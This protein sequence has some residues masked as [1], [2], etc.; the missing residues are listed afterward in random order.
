MHSGLHAVHDLASVDATTW[1][2]TGG[3]PTLA[4]T[5]VPSA[6]W[7]L[8]TTDLQGTSEF[9]DEAP[10]DA[11]IAL[12]FMPA[13]G[14]VMLARRPIPAVAGRR[15]RVVH[16]PEGTERVHLDVSPWLSELTVATVNFRS[17]P[18]AAAASMMSADV[19]ASGIGG[20]TDR[21]G[22]LTDV[23][24][25]FKRGGV[26]GSIEQ[27]AVAYE[28]LQHRRAGDG[29]DYPSWRIRN[30]TLFDDDVDRLRG[31]LVDL[32]GGGPSFT[33]VM[34]TYEPEERWLRAAIDSV[35]NQIHTRWQLVIVDDASPGPTARR[36]LADYAHDH[37]ILVH[38]RSENGHIAAA[39]N[40]GIERATGEFVAFMD[41]DDELAPA[42][43][44]LLALASPQADVLY[45]DEDKIDENGKHFDPHCKP[46]WNPELLFGQNY[47]SHLTAIRRIVLQ[48]AGGLRTGMDGSQDHD[49]LLRV[50]ALTAPD[51]IVHV[52]HI[53]YHWRAIS[54]STAL[55]TGAKDYVEAAS[56][57][58]LRERLGDGWTVGTAAA[59]TAYRCTPP[60]PDDIP[61]VSI[62]IPTRDRADLLE[63]CVASLARTTW[64]AFEIVIID[65]DSSDPETLEWL[66]AFDNGHDRRVVRH[67]GAFNYSE[68]NNHGAAEARGELLCL[69]NNDTEVIDPDWLTEMVRWVGQPGIG[70]VGAKLLYGDDRIQHAG[71][72]LGLGGLAGHGHHLLDADAY[73][74]FSRLTIAHEVGAVTAACMLTLRSTWDLLGGLDPELA[75]AFNDVDYCLRVRHHAGQRIIWTPHALLHHHE[76]LSRGA[77]D[78]PVK[79]A[80]FNAEVETAL[81]RWSDHLADDPAYSPNLTLDAESF[82]LAR[83]P[84]VKA[85]WADPAERAD[86]GEG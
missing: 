58:A 39:T 67:P 37:R 75:V 57:A 25:A 34:P 35:R 56:I 19:A 46:A 53:A 43:L 9:V 16:V 50:T 81:E 79:V 36:V 71:V 8:V 82:T 78:D 60:I 44:A 52:P 65:N 59:P 7:Y 27:V 23:R 69:L 28:H 68:V 31:R 85:P 42:A 77:E 1:R 73:G 72:V 55:D 64:P 47:M 24:A 17:L 74:Y 63:Q 51:R 12:R 18:Q 62:L 84:R 22:L 40:D 83:Q 70:A 30:A 6:G 3:R 33:I 10:D 45:T 4:L 80:R 61:L 14:S 38:H 11:P 66:E 41:H 2:I 76:S 5:D 13:T 54:G 48:E 86:G 15:A 26:R 29:V 49:L 32:P 21:G 20:T